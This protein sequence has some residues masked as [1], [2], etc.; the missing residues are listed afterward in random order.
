V[1]V[2]NGAVTSGPLGNSATPTTISFTSTSGPL[3]VLVGWWTSPITGITYGGAAL[4]PVVQSAAGSGGDRA[5]IWKLA[6]PTAGTANL[7]LTHPVGQ[8]AGSVII[9]N[10]TGQDTTTPDGTSGSAVSSTT[11]TTTGS[12]SVSGAATGDLTICVVANGGGVAATPTATGAGTTTEIFDAASNAEGTE[13]FTGT[14]VVTAV[15]AAFGTAQSWAIAWAVLKATS[16]P[17][18]PVGISSGTPTWPFP[19]PPL[20][21]A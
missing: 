7:V 14:N 11:G 8:A 3:Y 16:G 6:S 10:T 4:S 15:S 12:Q 18:P 21:V 19:H 20:S 2:T 5:E 9:F 17:L 13:A 1:A